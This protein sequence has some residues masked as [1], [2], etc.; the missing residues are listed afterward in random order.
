MEKNIADKLIRENEKIKTMIAQI[1]AIIREAVSVEK[2]AQDILDKIHPNYKKSVI[3]LLHYRVLRTH[4]IRELQKKLGNMG[5]SRFAKSYSHVMASLQTNRAIL[6]ALLDNAPLEIPTNELSFKKGERALNLN[7]KALLGY[8]TKSRRTRIMVTMPTE[9]ADQYEMVKAMLKGGMNCAR[10]NCAH[11]GPDTW[12]K[13]IVNVRRA[14]KALGKKCKIAMDLAGPKIRTGAI[15]GG[16]KVLKIRPVKDVYGKISE[17]LNIWIGS[18]PKA[19]FLHIPILKD[20]I[21]KLNGKKSL[22]LTDARNKKRQFNLIKKENGGYIAQ[23]EKTTFIVTGTPLF[24]NKNKAGKFIKVGE[25]PHKEIPLVLGVGDLLRLDKEPL[26][27]EPAI[28]DKI[29]TVVSKAHISC[30]A[31]EVFAQV[32]VGE[33]IVFDDGKIEGVI[34]KINKES[35]LIKIT[36]VAGRTAKLRAEKGINFPDSNLTLHGLTTKDKKDLIFIVKHADVVN[37]SFV[38]RLEDVQELFAELN[39]IN[40]TNTLGII[41]K[42]E[43]QNGFN[44]LSDILLEA[45]QRYPIGVMIARGDLAIEAGWDNIGRVQEEILSLCQA[46][47]VTDIWATQV[48][49]GLAKKGV[50]SRSEITD[51]VMAVRADCVM[52]NKGLYILQAIRL[53]DKILT[54]MDFYWEKNAPM[55]PVM[56]RADIHAAQ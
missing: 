15:V 52:L 32:R 45:M 14:S 19:G 17:P 20:D 42:I 41:L 23:S 40:P 24:F 55:S 34:K 53:L 5:L 29:G 54:D 28:I 6:Q 27:G 33:R 18:Q 38:N 12:E 49:E 30:T 22:F 44:H 4:D 10:I 43:T 7:A 8:R 16:P 50:P 1:D 39:K 37:F 21:E 13:I 47:H 51:T 46:A 11:D 26:L 36:N 48:L 31:P 56:Q 2:N 35:L 9:A 3:N 25:L